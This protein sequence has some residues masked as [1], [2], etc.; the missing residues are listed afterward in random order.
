MGFCLF[1]YARTR[2]FLFAVNSAHV[3]NVTLHGEK[4]AGRPVCLLEMTHPTE[5]LEVLAVGAEAD[6]KALL[7]QASKIGVTK[8]E[9]TL[10]SGNRARRPSPLLIN[11]PDRVILVRELDPA[12]FIQ[13][14]DDFVTASEI[15][16]DDGKKNRIVE[17][18]AIFASRANAGGKLPMLRL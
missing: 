12:E 18:P 3:Q 14:E 9:V 4:S 13:P 1:E 10:I 8:T 17:R 15:F 7:A 11:R 6:I 5:S 16:M 2:G